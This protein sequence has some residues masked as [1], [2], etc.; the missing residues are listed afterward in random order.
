M[1]QEKQEKYAQLENRVEK[2]EIDMA[3]VHIKLKRKRKKKA[4]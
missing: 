1:V 3:A 4:E 2:L